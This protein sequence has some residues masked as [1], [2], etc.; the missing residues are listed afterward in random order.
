MSD[1]A[2]DHELRDI[3]LELKCVIEPHWRH[4]M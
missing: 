2:V 4:D 1:K 3:Y